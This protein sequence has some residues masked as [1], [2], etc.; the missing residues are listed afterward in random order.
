MPSHNPS[1][2]T[3][4]E[5]PDPIAMVPR[6]LEPRQVN[7]FQRPIFSLRVTNKSAAEVEIL[8][9]SNLWVTDYPD[10]LDR[11]IRATLEAPAVL[12]PN[13]ESVLRFA[14]AFV[15]E[16]QINSGV[17]PLRLE[18]HLNEGGSPRRVVQVSNENGLR[19]GGNAG[20]QPVEKVGMGITPEQ[21]WIVDRAGGYLEVPVILGDM[22]PRDV[23]MRWL[24][25]HPDWFASSDDGIDISAAG[26]FA[27]KQ[28][29]AWTSV[30]VRFSPS[31]GVPSNEV[32][33]I[34]TFVAE[35]CALSPSPGGPAPCMAAGSR[36]WAVIA[37]SADIKMEAV[38]G[39]GRPVAKLTPFEASAQLNNPFNYRVD[40]QNYNS[41]LIPHRTIPEIGVRAVLEGVDVSRYVV[42]ESFV[43]PDYLAPMERR[44]VSFRCHFLSG[45]PT[46][47][48]L[49]QPYT[50]ATVWLAARPWEHPSLQARIDPGATDPGFGV[51]VEVS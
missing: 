37:E 29:R 19:I 22:F 31:A 24:D 11:G 13:Q 10:Q 20:I 30:G 3:L 9:T 48:Y 14:P 51:E 40:I 27:L 41:P 47:R 15:K 25:A 17:F 4:S 43:G 42:L 44:H 45:A 32:Q 6:S 2:E 23:T 26:S 8:S 34:G 38:T 21:V 39:P 12:K 49:L 36:I 16:G 35:V 33:V 7:M 50:S 1:A 46:G 28:V 5:A 18:L